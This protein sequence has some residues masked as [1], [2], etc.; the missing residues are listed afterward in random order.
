MLVA[1]VNSGQYIAVE[2]ADDFLS[3]VEREH[4]KQRDNSVDDSQIRDLGKQFGVQ[5]LCVAN[6]SQAFGTYQVSARIIDVETA[7]VIAIGESSSPLRSMDD[8]SAVSFRI[9]QALIKR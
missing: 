7:V 3:A 6:I 9:V 8:L 5:Y 2:R 1:L 4:V